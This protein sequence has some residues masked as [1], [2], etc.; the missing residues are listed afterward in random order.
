MTLQAFVF[1]AV[2]II[3]NAATI[4]FPPSGAAAGTGYKNPMKMNLDLLN[5][6][7]DQ[8]SKNAV[9][10]HDYYE[11][12]ERRKWA[13][14]HHMKPGIQRMNERNFTSAY[15]EFDFVLRYLPNHPRALSLMG[16][17]AILMNRPDLGESYFKKAFELY[18]KTMRAENH[19]DYGRFLYQAGKYDDAI[20]ALK[21]SLEMDPKLSLAHYFLGLTYWA[22]KDHVRANHH[23]QI[24]YSRGFPL[25]ELREKLMA[26]NAWNPGIAGADNKRPGQSDSQGSKR[27]E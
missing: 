17:L 26:A 27:G 1:L 2:I 4:L 16:D 24:V 10:P 21:K 6:K 25:S 23:A 3:A 22:T 7:P 20:Q 19:K 5:D 18:P 9:V 11:S 13:E 12:E 8:G 15:N 14:F